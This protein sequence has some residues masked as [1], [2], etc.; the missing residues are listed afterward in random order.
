MPV[1]LHRP[2]SYAIPRRYIGWSHIHISITSNLNVASI[3]F[4]QFAVATPISREIYQGAHSY[5]LRSQ[6]AFSWCYHRNVSSEFWKQDSFFVYTRR[7]PSICALCHFSSIN[8]VSADAIQ[9]LVSGR[10]EIS[11]LEHCWESR[12]KSRWWKHFIIV[13][14][15]SSITK[16]IS[17]LI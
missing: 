15:L 17:I 1:P 11:F 16:A 10:H 9:H 14:Y 3:S 6:T 2:M 8:S 7:R 12:S 5:Q 4:T 13:S